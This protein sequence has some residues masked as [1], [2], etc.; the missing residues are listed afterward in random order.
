MC[1]PL[2]PRHVATPLGPGR[3]IHWQD[4]DSSLKWLWFSLRSPRHTWNCSVLL[5]SITPQN[6]PS[7]HA[8]CWSHCSRNI[9][10]CSASISLHALAPW[11]AGPPQQ[12]SMNPSAYYH[13]FGHLT[14]VC[15]THYLPNVPYIQILP[16]WRRLSSPWEQASRVSRVIGHHALIKQAAMMERNWGWSLAHSQ[17]GTEALHPTAL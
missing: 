12:N 1:Q 4:V 15:R 8:D 10:Y 16:P 5:L 6:L 7:S 9:P 11:V 17:Q 13:T 2:R 3:N 14:T